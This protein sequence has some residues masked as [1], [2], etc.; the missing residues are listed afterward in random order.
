MNIGTPRPIGYMRDPLYPQS[1]KFIIIE[2]VTRY[3]LFP[4]LCLHPKFVKF[5][6]D[7]FE[8]NFRNHIFIE[9]VLTK[10][11]YFA[12]SSYGNIV[13][14]YQRYT[15]VANENCRDFY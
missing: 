11:I 6:R 3:R 8:C 4:N 12:K 7:F 9:F 14:H 15:I 10:N 5:G 1:D 2:P 13:V